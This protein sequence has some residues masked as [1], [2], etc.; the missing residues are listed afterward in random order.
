[1]LDQES[2]KNGMI[3]VGGWNSV[4]LDFGEIYGFLIDPEKKETYANRMLLF[5]MLVSSHNFRMLSHPVNEWL[6]VLLMI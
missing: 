1:M 4:S 2:S 3:T 6:H 5:V